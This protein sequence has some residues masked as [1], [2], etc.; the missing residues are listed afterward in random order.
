[1]LT[2][3]VNLV[4][5]NSKVNDKVTVAKHEESQKLK[6]FDTCESNRLS[7]NYQLRGS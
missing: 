7:S 3:N 5:E 1:M 6:Q 2:D 4:M